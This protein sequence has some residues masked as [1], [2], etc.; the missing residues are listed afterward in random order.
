[1]SL[2]GQIT[3][4]FGGEE[5]FVDRRQG[6]RPW[7]STSGTAVLFGAEEAFA[8]RQ[9]EIRPWSSAGWY[10]VAQ[11]TDADESRRRRGGEGEGGLHIRN[12]TTQQPEGCEKSLKNYY[13][14]KCH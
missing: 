8:D 1:M 7:S 14:N 4:R 10:Y 9:Q 13:S 2:D 11:R 5:A 6:I 12:L 3:I